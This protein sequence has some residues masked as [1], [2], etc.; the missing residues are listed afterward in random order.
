MT[1]TSPVVLNRLVPA[2][3]AG[4]APAVP[5]GYAEVL[6]DLRQGLPA[7]FPLTARLS[8]ALVL[9]TGRARAWMA[10]DPV[11]LVSSGDDTAAGIGDAG[12]P[13]LRLHLLTDG[14]SV[15]SSPPVVGTVRLLP[16]DPALPAE[17]AVVVLGWRINAGTIVGPGRLG[18]WFRLAW[19]PVAATPPEPQEWR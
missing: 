2:A 18:S 3:A 7:Q 14:R 19:C 5:A 17:I 8:L 10:A 4:V 15:S 9:A 13:A 6:D 12:R 1:L 11:S 16:A